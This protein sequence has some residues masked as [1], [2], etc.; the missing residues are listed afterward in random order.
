[1]KQTTTKACRMA[2]LV[3]H[4]SRTIVA[5]EA[6]NA[7]GRESGVTDTRQSATLPTSQHRGHHR[8]APVLEVCLMRLP[9]PL[10][11]SKRVLFVSCSP[12]H[13]VEAG[14]LTNRLPCQPL[15]GV[16]SLRLSGIRAPLL[17]A[18]EP[19]LFGTRHARRRGRTHLLLPS[20]LSHVSEA[21]SH[22]RI[23]VHVA[24]SLQR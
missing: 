15:S 19:L 8:F 17:L 5:V 24:D 12:A 13:C 11:P 16:G 3:R 4:K 14:W 18:F 2:A 9:F 21:T 22:A 7:I 10:P 20:T 23:Q 1:M 6:G